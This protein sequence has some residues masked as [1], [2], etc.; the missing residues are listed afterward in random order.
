MLWE[1]SHPFYLKTR[2]TRKISQCLY[3]WKPCEILQLL[4]DLWLWA[5]LDISK[6]KYKTD[7]FR[8]AEYYK[9]SLT[10]LRNYA[11]IENSIGRPI[12]G[13]SIDLGDYDNNIVDGKNAKIA[14]P[15]TGPKGKGTLYCFAS[16][17]TVKDSWQ[18]DQLD[19]ETHKNHQ[20][21]TFYKLPQSNS[22][23]T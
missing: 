20:R 3:R 9:K 5:V 19:I 15:V 1:N 2:W 22:P 11:P 7:Q 13:S 6:W 18:I 17:P 10:L 8:E 14:I 16:R 12:R 23:K 4:E 21:W